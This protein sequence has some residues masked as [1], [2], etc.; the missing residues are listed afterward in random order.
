[1]KLDPS[2]AEPHAVLGVLAEYE[3]DWVT[4][5]EEHDRAMALDPGDVTANFWMG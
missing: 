4:A 5:R 1:M 2:L 3:R